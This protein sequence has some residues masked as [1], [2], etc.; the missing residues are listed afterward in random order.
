MKTTILILACLLPLRA[1][2]LSYGTVALPGATI[3]F[4]NAS[5][6]LPDRHLAA[7]PPTCTP[8]ERYFNTAAAKARRCVAADTWSD[9][10]G[11]AYTLPAATAST[12][13][14]VK[15][16]SGLAIDGGGVLSATA[17]GGAMCDPFDLTRFCWVE[18]FVTGGT[19]S[20]Q[21][22]SGGLAFYAVSSGTFSYY[23]SNTLSDYNH[24]GIARITS[25]TTA[26]SGGNAKLA[27]SGSSNPLNLNTWLTTEW[28]VRWI[29]KLDS[30]T[31]T[32]V[33]LGLSGSAGAVVPG[34]GEPNF[35]FRYDTDAAFADHTKN[36][37]GSWVAQFCGYGS[38]TCADTAGVYTVLN[39]QPDTSWHQFR[40]Y[41]SGS[42]IHWQ[43]DNNTPVTMCATG[44][45]M[46][47]PAISNP[48]A[49]NTAAPAALFGI[50]ATTQ[51]SLYLDY[52]SVKVAGF[53]RY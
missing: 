18:D 20:G 25:T 47:L 8:G 39:I 32:R 52:L 42:T 12:L 6:V 34:T 2:S 45:N 19:S 16:G 24:P 35:I 49:A 44:C 38:N 13:G 23:G 21:V 29:I 36:T 11:A 15:V 48:A 14:G 46:T 7:D 26:N 28:E 10:A 3:D 22:G 40:I 17:S 50:S 43:L 53:S 27:S 4:R 30:V 5:T 1:Q 41:R 37:V 51:R 9:E 31:D 33:R